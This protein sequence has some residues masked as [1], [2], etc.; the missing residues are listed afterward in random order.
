MPQKLQ[1]GALLII[2]WIAAVSVILYFGFWTGYRGDMLAKESVRTL[3]QRLEPRRH[4]DAD[5]MRLL[6]STQS[7][8]QSHYINFEQAKPAGTIRVC[9][10]GDSNTYGD[11]VGNRHDYPSYLQRIFKQHG[12]DQVQ[13]LN[14]GNSWY[15]FSQIYVMW[16][17]IAS[18]F[19]CDFVL[20]LPMKF[21]ADRDTTFNHTRG[22]LP[23][24]IHARLVLENDQL[25]LLTP[26]GITGSE[27]RSEYLRA[28]PYWR[29]LRYDRHPPSIVDA[30][31]PSGR[32]IENPFYYDK[33][34]ALDEV[35]DIYQKIIQSIAEDG[36]QVI[37]LFRGSN[38]MLYPRLI[39]A[40][41]QGIGTAL[42]AYPDSFPY[43]AP[44]MHP[45]SWGQEYTATTFFRLLTGDSKTT[46]TI[47]TARDLSASMVVTTSKPLHDYQQV[48]LSYKGNRFAYF[49]PVENRVQDNHKIHM[50]IFKQRGIGALLAL[51]T[52]GSSIADT[53]LMPLNE[54]PA[55][56]AELVFE[57][58]GNHGDPVVLGKVRQLQPGVAIFRVYVES[59]YQTCQEMASGRGKS[60]LQPDGRLLLG[61]LPVARTGGNRIQAQ[62]GPLLKL[63]DSGEYLAEIDSLQAPEI[64][65]IE[66]L[67]EDGTILSR[68]LLALHTDQLDYL[69]ERRTPRKQ[70]RLSGDRAAIP[71][72]T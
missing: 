6:G 72:K 48:W 16:K 49:V 32:S 65:H 14:F 1:R 4:I 5:T 11:E 21:W 68:P 30:L 39:P 33:R 18:R 17:A 24:Y 37:V 2:Y 60:R 36:P 71:G 54:V 57:P 15:G 22:R 40:Q 42:T 7:G 70:I 50:E 26:L 66:L 58:D 38:S 51:V 52:P 12:F 44:A 43:R 59:D 19:D 9:A 35:I 56:G 67:S 10:L 61:D 64:I 55:D 8:K 46:V 29:Y 62:H 63:C 13:V 27:R 69:R 28:I 45:S 23:G 53:C 25:R 3:K 31:L 20:L 47:A 34:P 41:P